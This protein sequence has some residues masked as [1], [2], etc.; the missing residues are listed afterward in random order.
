MV[1]AL[2][3]SGS[4][5]G[6]GT[7]AEPK[8]DSPKSGPELK[9]TPHYAVVD[10]MKVQKNKT[11]DYLEIEKLWK[12]IHQKRLERGMIGG[13]YLCQ[14]DN[15]AEESR[16]YQYLTVAVYDSFAKL[17]QPYGG[18]IFTAAYPNLD[19]SDFG[20]KTQESRELIRSEVWTLEDAV[21]SEKRPWD[22][23]GY[24]TIDY[25]QPA[26]GK[27]GEYVQME[28]QIF[29]KLHQE[30]INRELMN[31]WFFLGLRFPAGSDVPFHY[32]TVNACPSA[33]T[34]GAWP[35]D[36]VKSVFTEEEMRS[37]DMAKVQDLRT[38]VRQ[39]IWKIV[40]RVT[41]AT[42]AQQEFTRL[43][44]DWNSAAIKADANKLDALLADD[45]VLITPD[46]EMIS[47]A[48][49]L[50]MIRN[51]EDVTTSAVTD[52]LKVRVHGDS[53][54]VTGR[55]TGQETVKGKDVSGQYMFTDAW[56]RQEGRWRCASTQ[57]ARI[58]APT[59]DAV[60][61]QEL[62]K[63]GDELT[64]GYVKD[65]SAVERILS[66]DFIFIAPD[67]GIRSKA[68]QVED[69]KSGKLKVSSLKAEGV[70]VR[71]YGNAA[72]ITGIYDLRGAKDGNDYEQR[73]LFT[74][75]CVRKPNGW[76]I[77]STHTCEPQP[78]EVGSGDE[79]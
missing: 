69:L 25:M 42:W 38:V 57:A 74:D 11:A 4:V 75:V 56:I 46:G 9:H 6:Q 17:E 70:K 49:Q 8:V 16:D 47:K 45:W 21:M 50:A 43:E 66:D 22:D 32:L 44:N 67:G 78:K 23:S 72:V 12:A 27:E 52:Q 14:V 36:L 18:D 59:S 79:P 60:A 13:W 51:G 39:D 55:F 24:I 5:R 77:V 65:V 33:E 76:Q 10:Y 62:S 37:W 19:L 68:D 2:A 3:G 48:E 20:K 61:E 53:A 35:D 1:L 54:F 64:E 34:A 26:A 29:H 7:A 63:L 30:R 28:R 40:D 73:A 31:A 58:A 15:P 71:V 41:P